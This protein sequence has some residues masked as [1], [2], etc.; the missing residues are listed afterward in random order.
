VQPGQVVG[1][2]AHSRGLKPDDHCGPFQPRP[3][4]DLMKNLLQ[5]QV[6]PGTDDDLSQVTEFLEQ[7]LQL[8]L[9]PW[10]IFV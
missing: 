1:D 6:F 10:R 4:Y 8:I 7:E 3:S 5:M 9:Y 2:P